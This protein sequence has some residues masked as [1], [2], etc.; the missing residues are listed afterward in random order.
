[1]LTECDIFFFPEQMKRKIYSTKGFIIELKTILADDFDTARRP[2]RI[3]M[4]FHDYWKSPT[5]TLVKHDFFYDCMKPT[6][7]T[8]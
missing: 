7:N 1:M 4:A 2:R 6:T 3:L 8:C 5:V